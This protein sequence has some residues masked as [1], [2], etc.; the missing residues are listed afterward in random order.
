VV[1]EEDTSVL[2]DCWRDILRKEVGDP[3]DVFFAVG[4]RFKVMS[5]FFGPRRSLFRSPGSVGV[6]SKAMHKDNAVAEPTLEN[7]SKRT[8]G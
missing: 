7:T 4:R 1:V 5:I 3:T 2:T 6:R 8:L